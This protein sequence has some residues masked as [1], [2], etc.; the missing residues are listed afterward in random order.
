MYGYTHDDVDY[1]TEKDVISLRLKSVLNG[2]LQVTATMVSD[3]QNDTRCGDIMMDHFD[4]LLYEL[5]DIAKLEHIPFDHNSYKNDEDVIKW[6]NLSK[7]ESTKRLLNAKNLL[8]IVLENLTCES[9]LETPVVTSNMCSNILLLHTI[10]GTLD[11]H[12]NVINGIEIVLSE[13]QKEFLK[14]QKMLTT[15]QNIIDDPI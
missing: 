5:S 1:L 3:W 13:K 8:K 12:Y 14:Q 2:I 10:M 4:Y 6:E 11:L 7:L 15:S 9:E